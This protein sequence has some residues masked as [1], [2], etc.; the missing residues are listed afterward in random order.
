MQLLSRFFSLPLPQ[1]DLDFLAHRE[2]FAAL[3]A[4]MHSLPGP[5][6]HGGSAREQSSTSRGGS[7]RHMHF[8][9]AVLLVRRFNQSWHPQMLP[10]VSPTRQQQHHNPPALSSPPPSLKTRH[11]SHPLTLL[12]AWQYAGPG[13]W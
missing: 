1:A 6:R 13:L 9:S 10:H 8:F 7:G 5:F 11:P 2:L 12:P 3:Q 4:L